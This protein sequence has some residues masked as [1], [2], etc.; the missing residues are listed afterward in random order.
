MIAIMSGSLIEHL[1]LLR[2]RECRLEA[3]ECLFR[4]GDSVRRMF[5]VIEGSMK[6]VRVSEGG[7]ELVL[8]RVGGGALLAE[9]SF[10]SERYHCSAQAVLPSRLA[11]VPL[12]RLR[13]PGPGST[14]LM[15]R[16]ARHLAHELQR[17]R[18]LAEILALGTVRQRL[19]AWLAAGDGILP[20]KGM[21]L[22]LAAAIAVTP[23]A[24]YRELAR[25]RREAGA[26]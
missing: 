9:A 22:E 15:Q 20:P 10:F 2:D 5:V 17:T 4:E 16:L 1:L 7:G 14:D 18:T 21:W 13:A 3:G 8:Q 19:D 12:G 24:L 26:A 6:L 11:A 23:E 25:R